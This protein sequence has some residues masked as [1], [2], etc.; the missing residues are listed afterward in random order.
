MNFTEEE[1]KKL[2]KWAQ[3][4]VKV[5]MSNLIFKE[6]QL[7]E[8]FGKK[9]TNIFMDRYH[10][11]KPLL[12]DSTITFKLSENERD[13]IDCRIDDN[14]LRVSGY[15]TLMVIPEASN[16]VRILGDRRK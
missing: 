8:M 13:I 2:P 15:L 1:M 5:L 4:K 12:K 10:E 16:V 14:S 9:E 7:D 3:S 6:K 11:E